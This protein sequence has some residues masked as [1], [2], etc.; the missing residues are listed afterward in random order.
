MKTVTLGIM[1]LVIIVGG[2]LCVRSTLHRM[3]RARYWANAFDPTYGKDADMAL[4]VV[5]SGQR[6]SVIDK[7]YRML[8]SEDPC[9]LLDYSRGKCPSRLQ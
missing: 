2:L 8:P 5:S 6:F 1:C 7:E 9:S 4:I 3:E